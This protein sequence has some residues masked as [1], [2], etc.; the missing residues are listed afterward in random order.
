MEAPI[1]ASAANAGS[2]EGS[3][4]PVASEN[5]EN[6]H[7]H[8]ENGGAVRTAPSV[9]TQKNVEKFLKKDGW[10]SAAFQGMSFNLKRQAQEVSLPDQIWKRYGFLLLWFAVGLDL[11][12]SMLGWPICGQTISALL[13]TLYLVDNVSFRRAVC[14]FWFVVIDTFFREISVGGDTKLAPLKDGRA[15]IFVVAPHINQF[16]DP[17]VVMKVVAEKA[18]RHVSWMAAAKS[19]RRRWIGMFARAMRCIAVERPEDYEVQGHGFIRSEGVKVFGHGGTRFSAQLGKG[20]VVKV[21]SAGGLLSGKVAQVVSDSEL[22]LTTPMLRRPKEEAAAGVAGLMSYERA[23]SPP[24]TVLITAAV[25]APAAAAAAALADWAGFAVGEYW[26]LITCFAFQFACAITHIVYGWMR[27]GVPH[28][29][30]RGEYIRES[31]KAPTRPTTSDPLKEPEKEMVDVT[32]ESAYTFLPYIDQAAMFDDVHTF[33]L[34]GGTIGI[35]PEGGTHD[36]TQLL[37][38]KWGVS[39]MLLGAMAKHEGPEPCKIS[40][41]PVGLNYFAPHKFRSTVSV[42]FGDPIQVDQALVDMYKHGSR[43]EKQEANL[44]VMRLVMAGMQA[45]TLQ[46]QDMETLQLFRTLRRLYVPFGTRLSVADNVALTQGFAFG[47]GKVK[48]DDRVASLMLQVSRYS[49]KLLQYRVRDFQVQRFKD[50]AFSAQAQRRLIF[51]SVF[52]LAT[53]ICFSILLLPWWLSFAPSAL[54]GRIVSDVQAKKVRKLSVIG[55]W[56]VLIACVV[57]P[58]FHLLYTA[59]FSFTFGALAGVVW[60]F[61]FPL[62]GMVA[63]YATEDGIRMMQSLTALLLLVRDNKVGQHLYN[64]REAL[65]QTLYALEEEQQW[66]KLDESTRD[67]LRTGIRSNEAA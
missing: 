43:E 45:C 29:A 3:S 54:V 65:R 67:Y 15:V 44:A 51:T 25:A 21:K 12:I 18:N 1:N 27:D 24:V 50:K 61:A 2:S 32:E 49:Q 63:V 28:S 10:S 14:T 60:F 8:E 17:V 31:K 20:A 19:M 46:A 5:K 41:V 42:D 36:G 64:D 26:A 48:A 22:L 40:V 57:V 37:P 4:Q 9:Q 59:C 66:L 62:G 34:E 38:L 33:L 35:F 39:M 52:R 30:M 23:L 7:P 16:I 6:N 13:V 56:K 58:L 11:I 53:L 47:Y 55:T